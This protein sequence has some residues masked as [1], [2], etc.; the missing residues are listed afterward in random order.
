MSLLVLYDDV[1]DVLGT[2]LHHI[3][4]LHDDSIRS[5]DANFDDAIYRDDASVLDASDVVDVMSSS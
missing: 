4:V 5:L 3:D 1:V 2:T